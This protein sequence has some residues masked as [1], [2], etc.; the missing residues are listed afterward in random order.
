MYIS[1]WENYRGHPDNISF[2]QF[3]TKIDGFEQKDSQGFE[4]SYNSYEQYPLEKFFIFTIYQNNTLALILHV[5]VPLL[6]SLPCYSLCS[7]FPP[8]IEEFMSLHIRHNSQFSLWAKGSDVYWNKGKMNLVFKKWYIL[9]QGSYQIKWRTDWFQF[10][11]YTQHRKSCLKFL[12][13]H[14]INPQTVPLFPKFW[15]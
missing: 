11:S 6:I 14:I 1:L 8:C 4:N 5:H 12:V 13:C 10:R 7:W 2:M 3:S 9:W 15:L